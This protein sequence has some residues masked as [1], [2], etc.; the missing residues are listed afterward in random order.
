MMRIYRCCSDSEKN[1]LQGF[2]QYE[3]NTL[4]QKLVDFLRSISSHVLHV[5]VEWKVTVKGDFFRKQTVK[6]D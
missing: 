3:K 4:K 6:S 2:E 5:L 1:P